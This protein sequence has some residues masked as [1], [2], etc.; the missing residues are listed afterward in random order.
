MTIFRPVTSV[1]ILL[2]T[3]GLYAQSAQAQEE[4]NF[5]PG[6]SEIPIRFEHLSLEDG[7]SQSSVHAFLQ[8]RNGFMWMPTQAG[9]NKYD[10][11]RIQQYVSDPWDST[12][13]LAEQIVGITESKDGLL[14]LSY[15]DG[16]IS[17]FD[18]SSGRS[19]H[20]LSS[21]TDSTMLQIGGA[22]G[23]VEDQNGI[24]WTTNDRVG[25]QRLDPVSGE[26]TRFGMRGFG[27]FRV[28]SGFVHES[29]DGLLYMA[30][31]RG[32]LEFDPDSSKFRVVSSTRATGFSKFETSNPDNLWQT[33]GSSVVRTNRLT[34]EELSFEL[35]ALAY[36]VQPD[37]D[38]NNFVWISGPTGVTRLD[39]RNGSRRTY[40]A[41]SEKQ[42][43]LV[44]NIAFR[45]Y[46]DRA[47]ILWVSSPG[48]GVSRFDPTALGFERFTPEFGNRDRL[49]GRSIW[50]IAPAKDGVIWV[51][52]AS[53]DPLMS[54]MVL[55]RID[56][57]KGTVANWQVGFTIS[58][59]IIVDDQNRVWI[60]TVLRDDRPHSGGVYTY[61][62][63]SNGLVS[64][65]SVAAGTLPHD[66]VLSL[67][68]S[69]DGSLWIGTVG[70]LTKIDGDSSLETTWTGDP[71][72]ED[73]L[74]GTAVRTLFEDSRGDVWA[75]MIDGT[76]RFRGGT[77]PVERILTKS[78]STLFD[79][80]LY[81]R[82]IAEDGAGRI[83]FA[84]RTSDSPSF[85][86]SYDLETEVITEYVYDPDDRTSWTGATPF[87]VQPHPTDANRIYFV[88]QS[89]G[90]SVLNV[91][92]GQFRTYGQEDGLS[93]N[94]V[95]D[96]VFDND[97]MLWLPSNGGLFR[98][99]PETEEFR[100]F[101]LEYGLQSLEFN[102]RAWA[103]SESGELFFG[104]VEGFNAFFPSQ[105]RENSMPPSVAITELFLSNGLVEPG[106]DS[107]LKQPII[108][109]EVIDLNHSQNSP[110]FSFAAL[111][112]KSPESNLIRYRLE[113]QDE[114][115]IDADGRTTASYTNLAPGSYTFQVIAAN[116]DGVWNTEGASV[117]LNISKPWWATYWAYV[118]YFIML[119]GLVFGVDRFQR[120][121]LLRLEKEAAREK[122]LEHAQEI[123]SAYTQLKATKEQLVQQEKL[124]SLGALTAGIAH[125]IKNPLNF[126]NNFAEVS[127]ELMD[128]L[129]DA[130]ASGNAEETAALLADLRGNSEQIAKH[131]KRADSIV[132]SM[133]MHAR[134]GTSEAESIEV[135][136][137]LEEYI[138][139][140]WHGMRA[141]D[142]DF[143][144]EVIR[145]FAADAGSLSVQPQELGRVIL[146]L[147]NNAFDA[148]KSQDNGEVTVTSARDNSGVTITVSDNGPGVPVDIREKIFEPFFT[149]KAT[150]EGTGLGLS[151]SH[152]IITKGH[153]GELVLGTSSTGGAS[154]I[155][156]LPVS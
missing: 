139:L 84:M 86:V 101:G 21:D 123:E 153:G 102:G 138:G 128:E 42:L 7:L 57:Q 70:G 29:E 69:Q 125:E 140:A 80:R 110:G 34:G 134:G 18:P 95:Y 45:I 118:M 19:T 143:R 3:L 107:P 16:S 68:S 67:L 6:G 33:V 129:A 55:N 41:N 26:V 60:G 122:E 152:D 93:N 9:L 120:A 127:T 91:S 66:N 130:V 109:T 111:H 11:G 104:G 113:P 23:I 1:F 32:L 43:G 131:G 10:G 82:A 13:V 97:G 5:L 119:S 20:Y 12:S 48:K 141:R 50:E 61:D 24:V 108:E 78:T 121:R 35:D 96:L 75:G 136:T 63:Q 114:N 83:W 132:K 149:T 22:W 64:A 65:Y 87:A 85:V 31:L 38:D 58:T 72:D 53:T 49:V 150:G 145:D 8:D 79:Q 98:F 92:S 46:A 100:M 30:G 54:G 106:D 27:R 17:R 76:V 25:L 71:E 147:L 14:Y 59:P 117:V 135:N 137:Y 81:A 47:G 40:G 103:K 28:R 116:S 15:I 88:S 124:A 44:G 37:P 36:D 155:I 94:T 4:V 105:L 51:V 148:V 112:F 2:L 62:P 56:R 154:F 73:P 115:W 39:I 90:L 156:R 99:N 144:S 52:G 133:M 74:P 89:S 77:G 151:L 146:N 142:D 126:V